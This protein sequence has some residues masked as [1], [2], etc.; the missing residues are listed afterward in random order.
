MSHTGGL[1]RILKFARAKSG[2]TQEQLAERLSVST[3]LVAKF[4]TDRLIPKPDTARRLDAVLDAGTLF[5]EMTAEAR[6]FSG[7]P[8]WLRPWLERE[9]HATMIRNFQPMLVPGLLQTEEYAR[10][11]LT[12]VGTRVT[13]IDEAV[14]GRL[15]R[16]KILHRPDRPCRL[17]AVVDEG[18]LR[19]PIGGSKVMADQVHAIARACALPNVSV[20]VVPTSVGAHPGLNGPMGIGTVDGQAVAFLDGPLGGQVTEDPDQIAEIEEIWQAIQEYALPRQ[21]SLELIMEVANSWS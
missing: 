3:S 10:C 15:A 18:A 20:T 13:D 14:A 1:G 6:A 19:R 5:Q 7:E 9:P 2:M 12:D 8:L 16:A 17:F 21:P 11:V 4:E